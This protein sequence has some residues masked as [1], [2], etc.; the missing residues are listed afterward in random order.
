[1]IVTV[2]LNP[3]IDKT[4]IVHGFRVGA[5]NRATIARVDVGGKGINVARNLKRLGC[6]VIATGFLDADDRHQTAAILARHGIETRFV[7][8]AGELRVNLKMIDPLT[9]SETEIN[10]PGCAVLAEAVASLATTLRGLASRASV[11][12]F[13]GSL[14][15]DTPVDLY[16][17]FVT[18]ARAAGVRSVLD[19][20]GAA[21]GAGIAAGPD[22]V[23]PNRAEAEELLGTEIGD[24]PSLVTAAQRLLTLGARTVVISL[25][26]DGAVAASPK[27]TWRAHPAAVA[28]HST[29]GAGDAMVAALAY[30]LTKSLALPE[31]LRLATAAGSAAAASI[32]P[33][34]SPNAIEALLPL[35]SVEPVSLAGVVA[36]KGQL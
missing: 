16:A 20:G 14:P 34:P 30:G 8:V 10:E 25:G 33:W 9:G 13:S 11:M 32:E 15:P 19:T 22:L 17:Q 6:D 27:G 21:L 31:A 12:V 29:V 4:L 35:V 7:P 28:A 23:K 26:P 18:L 5:T 36:R 3:A 1:V 2:T 24:E